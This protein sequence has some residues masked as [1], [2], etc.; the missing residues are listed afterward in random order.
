MF[1]CPKCSNAFDIAR[2]ILDSQT[3]GNYDDIVDKILKTKKLDNISKIDLSKL[4]KSI[5]YKKLHTKEKETVFNVL[6]DSQP[7][8]MKLLMKNKNTKF[9]ETNVAY[10]VCKNCAFNKIIKDGTLI[11]S[12]S[13]NMSSITDMKNRI[14]SSILPLTRKYLCPNKSCKTHKQVKLKEAVMVRVPNSYEVKYI[15]KECK[16]QWNST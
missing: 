4:L 15:C 16:T 7:E 3:G 9:N 2:T 5:S 6:Q 8:N 12:K 1:Y 14:H 13:E 11:Y 10:F